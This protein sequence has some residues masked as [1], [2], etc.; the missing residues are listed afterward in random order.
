MEGHAVLEVMIEEDGS[1]YV[2]CP[3]CGDSLPLLETKQGRPYLSCQ[4]CMIRMFVNGKA[5]IARLNALFTEDGG[6]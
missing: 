2:G 3:L 1:R 6:D 4:G 5:G